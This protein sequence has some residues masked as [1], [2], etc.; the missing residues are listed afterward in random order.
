[1]DNTE[2]FNKKKHEQGKITKEKKKK[3]YRED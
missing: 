2:K 3:T 1:M